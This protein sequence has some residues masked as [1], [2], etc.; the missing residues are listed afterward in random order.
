MY[1]LIPLTTA[2][3]TYAAPGQMIGHDTGN[4][5]LAYRTESAALASAEVSNAQCER[6]SA[7]FRYSVFPIIEMGG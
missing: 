3:A 2:D 6:D 1:V 5:V 4:S 7:S